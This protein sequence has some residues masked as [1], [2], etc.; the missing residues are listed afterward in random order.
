MGMPEYEE[1]VARVAQRAGES[2]LRDGDCGR[3]LLAF[4]RAAA[5]RTDLWQRMP[6]VGHV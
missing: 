4:E 2:A 3:A 5:I 6:Q 1:L